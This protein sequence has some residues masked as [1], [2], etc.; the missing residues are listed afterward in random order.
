MK[1]RTFRNSLARAV[2]VSLAV[3]LGG[4]ASLAQAADITLIQMADIHGTLVPHSAVIHDADGTERI[5]NAAGGLAKLKT[6]IDDIRSDNS[7]SL[8]INVGDTT[9]GTAETLFTVGDAIM[10]ALNAMGID[11]SVPGN[12]DFGHGPAV[13][14]SRFQ[15]TPTTPPVWDASN[16]QL[17][18][19]IRLM[20]DSDGQPCVHR[21]TFPSVAINLFNNAAD[22][23]SPPLP[24]PPGIPSFAHHKPVL[25]PFK[26]F[27]KDGV[28]VAVIGITAAM[29][30][31]MA[32]VFSIGLEFT[33]GINELPA[34]IAMAKGAGAKLIVVASELGLAQNIQIGRDFDDV[35]VVLSAHTHELTHEALIVSEK[36]IDT[37]PVGSGLN[38]GQKKSIAKGATIVVE[39]SEDYYIGRMDLTVNNGGTVTDMTWNAIP[40]DD[41]VPPNPAV[42]MLANQQEAQFVGGPGGPG[43]FPFHPHV[44]MPAGYCGSP[45]PAQNPL[46][47]DP[48]FVIT[49]AGP[50][51]N[52][53][54]IQSRGLWLT[55]PLT[56][57]VGSTNTLLTRHDDIE[58][59]WNNVI[60][61]ALLDVT[62]SVA[63]VDIS[64]TNGFRFGFDI[65][66]GDI[67][68]ADLYSHF[69]ISPALLVAEFS[70]DIIERSLE[71]ALDGI[72]NRNPYLQRGGWYLG[73]SSNMTQ[74]IDLD[75]RP[76]STSG[77]RIV[78]TTINGQP[79]NHGKTYSFASCYPH[80][81]P[82]DRVCRTPG[83]TNH[84]FFELNNPFSYQSGINLVAP[85]PIFGPV[86]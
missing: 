13:F 24:S 53:P 51:P 68:L 31:Q 57:V 19:N 43:T 64:M 33:Q 29:V 9:H 60:A 85:E 48:C 10:P 27:E 17:P 32:D 40:A 21:A 86:I 22:L 39:L 3:S 37:V 75:N 12:W 42:A 47:L 56:K 63:A 58:T 44:V 79:L 72:F 70:G 28:K 26:I 5:A 11:V 76:L 69:P 65:L 77:E 25:P 66:P 73:L 45:I 35:D 23:P 83:G 74:K 62:G 84:Q 49:P 8:L 2:A 55:E 15:V 78:K 82:L 14:R 80:G 18:A 61:D 52:L 81:N 67:T 6:V 34:A 54:V 1:L 20:S 38:N 4:T 36:K 71:V 30:Q 41:S 7:E 50:Q 16:C 46:G 59:V